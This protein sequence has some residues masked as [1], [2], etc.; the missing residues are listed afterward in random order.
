MI[1][2]ANGIPWLRRLFG[3]RKPPFMEDL[4]PS[5]NSYGGAW[6]IN[7]GTSTMPDMI[8]KEARLLRSDWSILGDGTAT[9]TVSNLDGSYIVFYRPD[10][11][12]AL[13][14]T[15]PAGGVITLP[16]EKVSDA[17]IYESSAKLVMVAEYGIQEEADIYLYDH[18]HAAPLNRIELSAD[19]LWAECLYNGPR[20]NFSNA[21]NWHFDYTNGVFYPENLNNRGY[22]VMGHQL[23]GASRTQYNIQ[24]VEGSLDDIDTLVLDFGWNVTVMTDQNDKIMV[25]NNKN[26]MLKK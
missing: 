19:N 9:A 25:D 3:Y 14:Q 21:Y 1:G 26:I 2:N 12:I 4:L 6:N 22:S 5:E 10:G 11:T 15:I 7:D 18:L 20:M 17:T 13:E 24:V 16:S 23:Q 8:G